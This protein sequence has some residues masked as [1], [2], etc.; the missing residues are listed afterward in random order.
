M[1]ETRHNFWVRAATGVV[2]A[3]IVLG[4]VLWCEAS[5]LGLLGLVAVG[6][7]WEFFRLPRLALASRLCGTAYIII[8]LSLMASFPRLFAFAFILTVWANDIFAYLVGVALGRHKIWPRLS[9]HKSWEGLIGGVVGAVVVAGAAG[10]FLFDGQW[11]AWS[12][13]GLFIAIGAVAGDLAES[14]FKRVAGVK[15]SGRLLPGHGGV[16]DRFD[17]MLGAAPYAYLFLTLFLR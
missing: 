9:P 13:G 10:Y 3:A 6:C 16:L 7:V 1:E 14:F 8:T 17:A 4:A 11:I 2:L 5:Y 15:D 12:V